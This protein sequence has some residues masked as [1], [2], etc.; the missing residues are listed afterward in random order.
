VT[1]CDKGRL[2][3][4]F[5]YFFL[6]LK[7]HH[8]VLPIYRGR[9]LTGENSKVVLAEFSALSL[10][11]L[12]QMNANEQ[13]TCSHF[14]SW[15]LG[16]GFVL[17]DE[18]CP[19]KDGG[20]SRIFFLS[21]KSQIEEWHVMKIQSSAIHWNLIWREQE[22]GKSFFPT[23]L[24]VSHWKDKK[25]SKYKVDF[26]FTRILNFKTIAIDLLFSIK[27]VYYWSVF[28]QITIVLASVPKFIITF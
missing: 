1:D 25:N 2:F 17:L 15:K 6:L 28:T 16:P 18:V 4:I 11:V 10:A 24:N 26:F 7:P 27:Q 8:L 23:L 20:K 21:V 3:W 14:H 19:W 22:C 13:L 5:I 9:Y 12:L